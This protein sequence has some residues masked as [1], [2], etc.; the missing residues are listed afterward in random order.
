MWLRELPLWICRAAAPKRHTFHKRP[1]C[2]VLVSERGQRRRIQS[3]APSE[4]RFR[5]PI[6]LGSGQS[7]V[8]CDRCTDTHAA[9]F[10]LHSSLELELE[11]EL[12][13]CLLTAMPLE[14]DLH[15]RSRTPVT[16][17]SPSLVGV[18]RQDTLEGIAGIAGIAG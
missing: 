17:S 10:V 9:A 2:R 12:D 18:S 8:L 1:S 3:G 6:R 11:L 15:K 7:V 14:G 16:L 4:S 13:S 5:M